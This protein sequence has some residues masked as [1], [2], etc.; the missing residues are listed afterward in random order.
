M[1]GHL[2]GLISWWLPSSA[3]SS[4]QIQHCSWSGSACRGRW[5]V[6]G[7]GRGGRR[8]ARSAAAADAG[9]SGL[10]AEPRSAA[11]D[12]LHACLDARAHQ[13]QPQMRVR[14]P[15]LGAS[16]QSAACM[17][18]ARTHVLP[19]GTA[20]WRAARPRPNGRS[21]PTAVLTLTILNR[22]CTAPRAWGLRGFGSCSGFHPAEPASLEDRIKPV[23]RV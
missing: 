9:G 8:R 5:V 21:R 14:V 13:L 11:P 6:W 2:Q 19:R 23:P 7:E 16:A 10:E 22:D 15:H 4:R 3:A 1:R 12:G 18:R 20:Q 17:R